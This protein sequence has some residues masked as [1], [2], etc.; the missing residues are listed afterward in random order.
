MATPGD[1]FSGRGSM[2]TYR[3][4]WKEEASSPAYLFYGEVLPIC[5]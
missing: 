1:P 3:H 2:L 4:L 5:P